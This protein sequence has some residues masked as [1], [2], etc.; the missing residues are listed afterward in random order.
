MESLK[1]E[2]KLIKLR[3]LE[4]S[5]LVFLKE[6]ENNP[7]FWTISQTVQAFSDYT[8]TKYIEQAHQNIYEALQQRWVISSQ[9]DNRSLGF[10]DL[11]DFD[12]RNS[13]VGLGIVIASPLE[14][15]KNY[16]S[17]ALKLLIDYV[18][19]HLGLRQIFVNIL[20]DNTTSIKLFSKFGFE[21]IGIKKD[22]IRECNQFKDEAMYQLINK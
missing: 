18:F 8:L 16:G 10:I 11:F 2:T 14:R 9:E 12:V 4:P 3:P 20:T 17:D 5:D 1:F 13:R 19:Q 6:V 7:E 22:W 21:L 15:G